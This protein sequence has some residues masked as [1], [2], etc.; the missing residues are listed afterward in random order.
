ML[1]VRKRLAD[2]GCKVQSLERYK[3]QTD[4]D[5]GSAVVKEEMNV[6]EA[7]TIVRAI[8]TALALFGL[9]FLMCALT[10]AECHPPKNDAPDGDETGEEM[11]IPLTVPEAL[12][13][14]VIGVVT[15]ESKFYYECLITKSC[16]SEERCPDGELCAVVVKERYRT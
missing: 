11:R 14:R 16:T 7:L 15:K 2:T 13:D 6:G 4:T 10:Q 3:D 12:G 8:L 1:C 9:G 5:K